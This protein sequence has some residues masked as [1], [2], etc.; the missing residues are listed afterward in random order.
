MNILI[1]ENHEDTLASLTLYVRM[2]G[3]VVDCAR[4][5]ESALQATASHDYEVI[6]SDIMLPDGTGWDLMRTLHDNGQHPYAI[7]MSGNSSA[8]DRQ[9]SSQSGFRLHLAKPFLPSALHAA[10]CQA[11]R[12]IGDD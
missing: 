4:S 5:V 11:D 12:S 6:L 9:A 2:S 8:E 1:V 7:A 10:L 3:H